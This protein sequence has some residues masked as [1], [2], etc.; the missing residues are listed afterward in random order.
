MGE[1][2]HI[3]MYRLNK[4][5]KDISL[6]HTF[7]IKY[8]F[9]SLSDA[10]T[11]PFQTVSFSLFFEFSICNIMY[12]YSHFNSIFISF[13]LAQ[14]LSHVF[15]LFLLHTIV[16]ETILITTEINKE[17]ERGNERKRDRSRKYLSNKRI[18]SI[19]IKRD[20]NSSATG[21]AIIFYMLYN[22]ILCILYF[23]RI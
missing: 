1:N 20:L 9:L 18:L 11:S 12:K 4:H 5:I 17:R 23:L 15:L 10:L 14:P 13:S 8:S 21:C 7:T 6:A 3:H 2:S 16:E 22:F 19:G